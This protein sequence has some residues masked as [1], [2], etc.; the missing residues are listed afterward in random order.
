[1]IDKRLQSLIEAPLADPVK[2]AIHGEPRKIKRGPRV[3][4]N[5]NIGAPKLSRDQLAER[6][7]K[8]FS[9]KLNSLFDY[10]ATTNLPAEKVAEHV[11]LYR[12]VQTGMDDK[13]K[14]VFTRAPDIK[15]VEAQLAWRRRAAA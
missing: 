11:G 3:R 7:S 6:K 10:Y 12:Q 14:P 15:T 2:L 5:D 4:E 13:G 9:A 8:Q 1:M